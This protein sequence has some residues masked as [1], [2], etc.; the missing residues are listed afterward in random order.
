MK[1]LDMEANES[2]SQSYAGFIPPIIWLSLPLVYIWRHL[3]GHKAKPL[4]GKKPCWFYPTNGLALS[5]FISCLI[6]LIYLV[7]LDD[8]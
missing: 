4:I 1:C 3:I 6:Y 8:Q 2:D 7:S 5:D